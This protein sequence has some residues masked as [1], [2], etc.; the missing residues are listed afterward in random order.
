MIW[1]SEVNECIFKAVLHFDPKTY[2]FPIPSYYL[3]F[4]VFI[5]YAAP[6][7]MLEYAFSRQSQNLRFVSN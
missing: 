6:N 1:C 4:I 7:Q 2:N 5:D 3:I